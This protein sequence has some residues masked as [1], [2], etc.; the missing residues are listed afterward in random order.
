MPNIY[1]VLCV[2][3]Q[4]TNRQILVAAV[5]LY[6]RGKGVDY[7]ITGVAD[8]AE[9]LHFLR[10]L[11]TAQ[12]R[13]SLMITDVHMPGMDGFSLVRKMKE[14]SLTE[15]VPVIVTSGDDPETLYRRFAPGSAPDGFLPKPYSLQ[16]VGQLCEQVLFSETA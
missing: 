14:N 11:N 10:G 13:L 4:P 6:F 12:A 5:E 15:S 16:R 9:A 3:D 2:E 1:R 7:L 8:G